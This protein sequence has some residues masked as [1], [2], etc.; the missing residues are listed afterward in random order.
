MPLL[1]AMSNATPVDGVAQMRYSE[2]LA[3]CRVRPSVVAVR[4]DEVKSRLVREATSQ[5]IDLK[6]E[7]A[8][9]ACQESEPKKRFE[10]FHMKPL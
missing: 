9:V 4:S 10:R 1:C 5:Q 2:L 7:R 6:I 3:Q 8:Q